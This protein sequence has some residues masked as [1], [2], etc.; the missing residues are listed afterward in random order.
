MGTKDRVRIYNK[1][2]WVSIL[3]SESLSTA[4]R[5]SN[6]LIATLSRGA[7]LWVKTA[8]LTGTP[9]FTPSLQIDDPDGTA[10]TVWTAATAIS[11]NGSY[12]YILSPDVLTGMGGASVTET[13]LVAIPYFHNIVLTYAGTPATDKVDTEAWILYF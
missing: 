4:T 5:T 11:A 2:G 10:L 3:A 6:D 8:N 7:L 1:S 13:A 12:L 9:T